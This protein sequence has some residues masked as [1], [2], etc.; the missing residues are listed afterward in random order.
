MGERYYDYDIIV[1]GAGKVGLATAVRSLELGLRVLVLEKGAG[2][3][4]GAT[5]YP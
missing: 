1:I 3:H 5:S 4:Y 2:S